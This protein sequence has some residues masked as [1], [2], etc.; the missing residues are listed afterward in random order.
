MQYIMLL[1]LEQQ[2]A[3]IETWLPPLKTGKSRETTCKD[4]CM[5]EATFSHIKAIVSVGDTDVISTIWY[6]NDE[7]SSIQSG[8]VLIISKS[9]LS[10][11]NIGNLGLPTLSPYQL[12]V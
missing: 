6:D 11:K 3:A 8:Q 12:G 5:L 9:V 1:K 2:M 10:D 4:V 7:I